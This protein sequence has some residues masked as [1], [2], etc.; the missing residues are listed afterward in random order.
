MTIYL[1]KWISVENNVNVPKTYAST[2]FTDARKKHKAL[3]DEVSQL[4]TDLDILPV[5]EAITKHTPKTQAEVVSLINS[6]S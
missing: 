2:S 6:L 1:L 3:K 4:N 5:D